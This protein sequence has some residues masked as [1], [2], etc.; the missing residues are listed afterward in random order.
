MRQIAEEVV[1]AR[2]E[3]VA[4]RASNK[5]VHD[6]F[7]RFGINPDDPITA[8]R[9]MQTI[10]TITKWMDRGGIVAISTIVALF[11]TGGATLLWQAIS[12]GSGP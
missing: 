11:I 6:T 4:E 5:A 12:K 7:Q 2:A 10:A 9:W 1:E 3:A 8:Q